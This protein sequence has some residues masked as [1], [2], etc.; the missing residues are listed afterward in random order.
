MPVRFVIFADF[1]AITEKVYG[2]QPD[3]VKSYTD[4]YQKHTICSYGYKVVCCYDDKFLKP[5]KIYRGEDSI[6]YFILDMLS[7]V[8][9]C[10]KIASEFQKP[11][12]MT[13][14]EEE[15]FKAAEEYHICGQKYLDTE[16]RIR[17]HCHITGKYRGSAHQ[18]CNLKL[19]LDPDKFNVPVI[20]HNLRGYD[21]HFI[22]QEIGSIGKSN[23]LSINCIPNNMEKYMALMPGKHLVFLDSFQ[24]MASS[25]ERLA[26]NLPT[27]AFKY[28]SQVFQDEK[29]A[30]MKQKGV[31]PY[32]YMDSF[33]KF[34]D[35][36]L[37]PKEEFYSIL[38]DEG[39]SDEQ[40][41]HAQK[42]WNTF[43]M[44]TMGE[45]HDLYLK[46]DILL[47]ADDFENFRKTYHQYYK[48]DPCHYFTSPALSWDAMLKMTGI[49]LELMVDVDMFQFIEK[50]LRGGISYI[51]NQHGEA[52]NE[53]M[54]EYNPEKPSK[55]IM[56]LDANNLYGWAMSQYL[57][58]GGFKWMTEKQIQKV[59]LAACTEDRKKGMILEVILEYPKELHELH[60][61]YPLAAEKMKVTKE[62]LSPYCINIQEQF[63]ISIGQVAKLIPT[64]SSKK[65]YVLHY[66]NLQLYLSLGLKLKKVHRV[67]DY[68][69]SPWLA[70]YI[71]FN[72]Q[73]RTNA[74]NAFEKDFFKETLTIDRPA[75]VGMCILDL[76]KTLMYD[77]HYNYVK[78]RY[79]N[80]AKLLFTDTDSLGYEIETRDVYKE[81][82]EDKQLFD[83]SDYPKDSLYFSAENKKVIRKFKDEAAGMPIREFV[84]LR[85]KMYSYVKDNGKNEKTAKGVRKYVIKKNITHGNYKDCLLN[86]K[87][88]LHSMRT[89]R[90]DHHQIGSY[91]LNKIS[92]S[93][94]VDKRFILEDGIHSYAYG[95]YQIG[96]FPRK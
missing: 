84:D 51:A 94:F 89:I 56:Y 66:R 10:Q 39:I 22:M 4:K 59:N 21:S 16:V 79:N 35:Q 17:D 95:H 53:Y 92:L 88:M 41:Q 27:D 38:T 83:N 28:T 52:N 34:S 45:Y 96:A 87:Q 85:C 55:Y 81:L 57:P 5:V 1:E 37:P 7:E 9:Y 69:P 90:S 93:C 86:V 47:L 20:F 91:Q 29:L 64:L 60:N 31:Y 74:K 26:A 68:D 48:L 42:V 24:F 77:F 75:Y 3:G 30:L 15:L 40:Y 12:Q 63:G 49:K 13:D 46:S 82:R 72:T 50:G 54:K 19:R 58:T 32:D 33:G 11:P 23:N 78:S 65:N 73:K 36:Q 18:D 8:E 2:C 14:E 44:R 61:D 80:K 6:S 43:N 76:S 71:N 67:L 25:L 70:Q 62:M